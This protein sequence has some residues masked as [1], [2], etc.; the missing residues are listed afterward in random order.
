M[1]VEQTMNININ[2]MSYPDFLGFLGVDNT[3]PGGIF[4]LDYWIEKSSINA[5]SHLLDL[6]CST[7]FSARNIVNKT[8]CHATGVDI[9]ARSIEAASQ[10]SIQNN[11][12]ERVNFFLGN[13]ESLSLADDCFSHITAGCCFGFFSNKKAALRE[14]KRV[15]KKDGYLCISSFY[16][17]SKPDDEIL[18]LVEKYIGFRPDVIWD[19]N[20]WVNFFS[21]EFLIV[22]EELFDLPVYSE[23]EIEENVN[24]SVCERPAFKFLSQ[25]QQQVAFDR[26]FDTRLILNEHAKYQ[27]V[28]L[29]V[30]RVNK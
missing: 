18:S 25:E 21:E 29:W 15:L 16:Y 27:S 8:G 26:Y 30:M 24:R 13:A 5:D 10:I 2:A 4:T 20:Y 23:D 3:P 12:S 6:A 9:S 17:D 7:G 19:Y 22:H 1:L 28:A 14:A 11:L